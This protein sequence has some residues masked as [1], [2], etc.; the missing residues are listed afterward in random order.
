MKKSVLANTIGLPPTLVALELVMACWECYQTLT[1]KSTAKDGI[2]IADL[3]MKSIGRTFG[4][5]TF[6][7]MID[8]NKDYDK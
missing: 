2:V 3:S 8:S 1:K 5:T 7:D 6:D 4:M